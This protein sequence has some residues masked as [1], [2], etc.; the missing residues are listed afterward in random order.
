ME[1]HFLHTEGVA[2]SNP[3]AR[4]IFPEKNGEIEIPDTVSTQELRENC[5]AEMNKWPKKVKHRNK[6]LARIYRPCSGRDSYRV[7]WYA[8]GK[9]QMKSFPT[10]SGHGGAREYAEALVKELAKQSQAIMLSPTQAGDA[11]AAIERSTPSIS[12]PADA[13]LSE[14]YH[15]NR[16]IILRRF[17]G[18]FS[19]YGVCDL[20]KHDLDFLFSSKPIA[21]FSAKSRN[22][23]RTVIRQFL[24]WA[25]ARTTCPLDTVCW[26]PRACAPNTQTRR[27]SSATRPK[28]FARC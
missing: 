28:S 15:Y 20:G 27:K 25:A 10:C 13:Q 22:H 11:L 2:G 24:E 8:A 3:A 23:Q 17:A 7:T 5:D 4:T 14:K 16:A 18:T 9:R 1:E 26:K 19:G 6:V 21:D 12:P